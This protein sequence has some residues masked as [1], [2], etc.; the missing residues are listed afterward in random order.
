MFEMKQ[1][2]NSTRTSGSNFTEG[3][4]QQVWAKAT[5]VAGYNPN[6]I[7][8]DKCGAYIRYSDY[9]NRNSDCGWEIDHIVPVSK[10][11]SD[12]LSNL[13][14]LHWQNNVSKGDGPDYGFCQV[15]RR[16]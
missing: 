15:S 11:G 3:D 13:Q 7:R 5:P 8:L 16:T 9:G 1:R 2:A 14:P 4:K 10:G 12:S 6:D